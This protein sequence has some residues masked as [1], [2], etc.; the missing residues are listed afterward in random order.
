M[1]QLLPA[2]AVYSAGGGTDSS[3]AWAAGGVHFTEM[4]KVFICSY[5]ALFF[6][7][8]VK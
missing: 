8:I 4:V 1:V 7:G 2:D 5:N 3:S 6:I